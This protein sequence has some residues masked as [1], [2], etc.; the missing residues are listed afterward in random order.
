[1]VEV[2][3]GMVIQGNEKAGNCCGSLMIVNEVY[4]W[5]VEAFMHIPDTG[6]KFYSIGDGKY[7]VIGA[8]TMIPEEWEDE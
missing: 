6:D 4:D 2:R 1:M 7:D 3:R 8:A 5:G